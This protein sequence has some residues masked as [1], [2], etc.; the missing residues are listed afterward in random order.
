MGHEDKFDKDGVRNDGVPY[1][2]ADATRLQ[3][4]V[5]AAETLASFSAPVLLSSSNPH[6]HLYLAA[7][8]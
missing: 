4:Y 8:D 3:S 7:L 6:Q 2:E 1:Y 5:D